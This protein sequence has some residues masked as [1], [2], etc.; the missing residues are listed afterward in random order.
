MDYEQSLPLFFYWRVAQ[1]APQ[2]QDKLPAADLF[3]PMKP[4]LSGGLPPPVPGGETPAPVWPARLSAVRVTGRLTSFSCPPLFQTTKYAPTPPCARYALSDELYG[5]NPT[6]AHHSAHCLLALGRPGE[7]AAAADRAIARRPDYTAAAATRDAA[8]AAA[9]TTLAATATQLSPSH[10]HPRGSS[11]GR[12]L[13]EPHSTGARRS[14]AE[15]G[16]GAGGGGGIQNSEG[17]ASAMFGGEGS[18][19]VTA[20]ETAALEWL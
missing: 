13:G 5:A 15:A 11:G 18:G 7:A 2:N 8:V 20:G 19:D 9:A 14:R 1:P 10:G 16:E 6:T 4:D 12:D 17:G 3:F